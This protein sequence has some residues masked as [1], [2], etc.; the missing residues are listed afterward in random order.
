MQ[1]QQEDNTDDSNADAS[2]D[3]PFEEVDND[4]GQWSAEETMASSKMVM[5]MMIIIRI[6]ITIWRRRK[7]CSSNCQVMDG[8][9]IT[10]WQTITM[11]MQI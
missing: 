5:V 6:I 3:I 4:D 10:I 8:E 1:D 2:M 11:I 9:V 7:L